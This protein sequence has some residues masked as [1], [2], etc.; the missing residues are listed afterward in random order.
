MRSKP[1]MLPC[2]PGRSQS[3]VIN[4]EEHHWFTADDADE[5][6]WTG[7]RCWTTLIKQTLSHFSTI[8]CQ[9]L[10][11]S[12]VFVHVGWI[13]EQG[14]EMCYVSLIWE[15]AVKYTEA[16]GTARLSRCRFHLHFWNKQTYFTLWRKHTNRNGVL[17]L[18][19]CFTGK[20]SS[21]NEILMTWWVVWS[22]V[23]H[24]Q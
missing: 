21:G 24:L 7:R 4:L 23:T 1:H 8:I 17:L 18:W 6:K 20:S 19:P 22:K 3:T 9:P 10:K 13:T 5:W 12:V 16:G 15:A 2:F 11:A 14:R